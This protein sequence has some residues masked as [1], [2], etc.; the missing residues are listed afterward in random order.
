MSIAVVHFRF[1]ISDDCPLPENF[2]LA[3]SGWPTKSVSWFVMSSELDDEAKSYSYAHAVTPGDG[4]NKMSHE[5]HH[6]GKRV[7]KTF[8]IET[9]SLE[10]MQAEA[11]GTVRLEKKPKERNVDDGL[12]KGLSEEASDDEIARLSV[13]ADDKGSFGICDVG[14]NEDVIKS[15]K[16][17]V[18]SSAVPTTSEARASP[19][20]KSR[21][22]T[23]AGCSSNASDEGSGSRPGS[24]KLRQKSHSPTLSNNIRFFSGNPIVETTEGIMHLYKENNLT[25]L[26]KGFHRPDMICMLAVP[27][28]MTVKDL[29]QFIAPVM[30]GIEQMKIIRDSTPNQYMVLIKFKAQEDADEFYMTY[31]NVRYNSIEPE[32]CYLVY[33]ASVEALKTSEGAC[34]P[35]QDLTELPNCPVCLE[36]MDESVDGILTI[37]C[38]HTFHGG[39][40]SQW[41]DTSCPVCRYL[42]TPEGMAQNIC[43]ECETQESLWICLICGHIGCGRY[44]GGHARSHYELTQHTYVM[45]LSN[46]RVWDYAGDNYVHRLIQ[47]KGDGKLVEYNEGGGVDQDEK[48][49]SITL[50]YTY[51]LTSQLESQRLYFEEKMTLLEKEAESRGQEYEEKFKKAMDECN[52]REKRLTIV[53]RE[54]QG[55]EKKTTQLSKKIDKLTHELQEEREM[56]KNLLQN[57]KEWQDKLSDTQKKIALIEKRK[58][59]EIKDLK[60]QLRDVMFYLEA[61][62]KIAGTSAATQEEIQDGQIIV[63]EQGQQG[64]TGR[65]SGR[66]SRKGQR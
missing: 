64:A 52:E 37:L 32:I 31:N 28:A 12:K 23:P 2:S 50:E 14:E 18:S 48:M 5:E 33:V 45:Q 43:S 40:L 42:Q 24:G 35:I 38:N 39:C 51:L 66:R 61:Q 65:S 17:T 36:R 10:T 60:E 21:S 49:D 27:P 57:Q 16:K 63:G 7:N 15:Y 62:Q 56:N 8:E 41:H 34:F 1:E 47:S 54:K 13:Q 26:E 22:L 55:Q 6:R 58:D 3:T 4:G 46:S 44:Q 59:E 19:S 9:M 53:Q 11:S 20:D 25:S 30:P 29:M